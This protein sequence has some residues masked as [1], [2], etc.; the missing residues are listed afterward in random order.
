MPGGLS[1]RQQKFYC[2][3]E[4]LLNRYSVLQCQ[5]THVYACVTGLQHS[6][7]YRFGRFT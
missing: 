7:L 6:A 1:D 5:L 4:S 2:F 3:K